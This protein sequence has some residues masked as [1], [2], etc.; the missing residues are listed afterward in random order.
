M[1]ELSTISSLPASRRTML[2][3]AAETYEDVRT[4][5]DF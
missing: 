3:G 4:G 5:Q 2:G 1:L